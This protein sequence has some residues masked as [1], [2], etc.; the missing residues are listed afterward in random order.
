MPPGDLAQLLIEWCERHPS[1]AWEDLFPTLSSAVPLPPSS[2]VTTSSNS[3]V[4]AGSAVSTPVMVSFGP[5]IDEPNGNLFC[6]Y[7]KIA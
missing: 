4:E 2:A 3:A 7:S 5:V 1:S 6:H